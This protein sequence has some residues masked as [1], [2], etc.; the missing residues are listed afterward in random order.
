LPDVEDVT[1]TFQKFLVELENGHRLTILRDLEI[2]R[3]V[4][5]GKGT[6]IKV[7]GEYDWS[8]RGGVIQWTHNDP[9]GQRDGGWIEIDGRVYR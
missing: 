8:K 2:T 7:R 3:A 9:T 1:G 4:P 6:L 5:V